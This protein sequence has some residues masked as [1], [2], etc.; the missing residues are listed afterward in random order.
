MKTQ[1]KQTKEER[2][3]E[4]LE[5]HYAVCA[6]LAFHLGTKQDGKKVSLALWKIETRAHKA[7]TEYCN[8]ENGMD[9]DKWETV[10]LAA[11][12][13]VDNLFGCTVPGLIINGDAR[14]YALKIDSESMHLYDGVGLSRDWGGNGI[15]SPEINGEA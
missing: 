14:G 9:Y 2:M 11:K 6:A 8:G 12:Y 13:D 15:L 1:K 4:R 7:A 5:K 10:M 3:T